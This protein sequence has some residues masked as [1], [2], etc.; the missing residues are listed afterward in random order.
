MKDDAKNLNV[1]KIKES[2]TN[3]DKYYDDFIKASMEYEIS[4]NYDIQGYDPDAFRNAL[5]VKNEIFRDTGNNFDI[6]N[7]YIDGNFQGIKTGNIFQYQIKSEDL[8]EPIYR[9]Y[10]SKSEPD[11]N[12]NI[13]AVTLD[14][15]LKKNSGDEIFGQGIKGEKWQ[16][17]NLNSLT[18]DKLPYIICSDATR[19]SAVSYLYDAYD[20]D[21]CGINP[22]ISRMSRN[23]G[24]AGNL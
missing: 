14:L 1:N 19:E 6:V 2:K 3:L 23:P 10:I 20:T 22:R 5:N 11:G 24:A 17:I 8:E 21:P 7:G 9:Y 18:P 4:Q 15:D 13:K 16:T 12:D